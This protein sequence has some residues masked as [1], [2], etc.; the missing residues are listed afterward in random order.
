MK[1]NCFTS[2]CSTMERPHFFCYTLGSGWVHLYRTL[3]QDHLRVYSSPH[4]RVQQGALQ[5]QAVAFGE[6]QRSREGC[7]SVRNIYQTSRV[8]SNKGE[9]SHDNAGRHKEDLCPRWFSIGSMFMYG[10]LSLLDRGR[11]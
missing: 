5:Q 3:S 4:V 2:V 9:A 1:G 11:S 8:R 6:Q 7:I 10:A